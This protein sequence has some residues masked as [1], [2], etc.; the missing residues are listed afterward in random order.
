MWL[1]EIMYIPLYTKITELFKCGIKK[2]VEKKVEE[3]NF[4]FRQIKRLLNLFFLGNN[5]F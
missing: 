4:Q 2:T 1:L 3:T 5:D